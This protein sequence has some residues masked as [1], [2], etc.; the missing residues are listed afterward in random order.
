MDVDLFEEYEGDLNGTGLKIGLLV[1]RFNELITSRLLQGA[2]QGLLKHQVKKSDINVVWVPGAFEIPL[3]AKHL[4]VTGKFDVIICLGAVIKGQTPHFEY[5]ST[6]VSNGISKISLDTE[7]PI[8][9][10]ILTTNDMDQA[11]ERSGGT[12][13]NKGYESATGA[14]QMVNLLKKLDKQFRD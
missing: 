8:M 6:Q 3:V 5:V 4:A 1:A 11:L 2:E 9:F 7:T 10:G 12:S 14:I 13:G